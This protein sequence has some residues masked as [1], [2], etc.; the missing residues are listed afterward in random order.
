MQKLIDKI[1]MN[2]VQRATTGLLNET[3]SNKIDWLRPNEKKKSNK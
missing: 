3:D 1:E 2:P